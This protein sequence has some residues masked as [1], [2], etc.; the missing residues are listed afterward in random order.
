MAMSRVRK[1]QVDIDNLK[2]SA[3][4]RNISELTP[5]CEA[6]LALLYP[7]RWSYPNVPVLPSFLLPYVEVSS[8]SLLSKEDATNVV[9]VILRLLYHS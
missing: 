3:R 6:L 4:Y 7:F 1:F 5:V 2:A 9:N 8:I